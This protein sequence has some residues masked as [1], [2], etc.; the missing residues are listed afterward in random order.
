MTS[1]SPRL[2]PL[3]CAL[4]LAPMAASTPA[5]AQGEAPGAA[6]TD[7]ELKAIAAQYDFGR[8]EEVLGRARA[9]IDRGGLSREELVQLHQFAGLA[10]FN[11][12]DEAGAERHFTAL[13]KLDPDFGL[14]PFSVAPPAIL[15]FNG[16]KERLDPQ[17]ELIRQ[18][19]RVEADRLRREAEERAQRQREEEERRRR[20]EALSRQVT[21]R[22]VEHRS[23][24]VNFLPFG[25]PQFGQ[26]R[27]VMGGVLAA[28]QSAAAITSVAA[29]FMLES[30]VESRPYHLDTN[31]GR[32]TIWVSG[33]PASRQVERDRWVLIK[34]AS[35]GAFYTLYG[36][37]VVDGI[38]HHQSQVETV[39]TQ[40]VPALPPRPDQPRRA[41][42]D[43]SPDRSPDPSPERPEEDGGLQMPPLT[44]APRPSSTYF[45]FPTPGGVGAG[46]SLRF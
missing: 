43:L 9:R 5:L 42:P 10:A 20:V 14:D 22:T 31:E 23:F 29:Y 26:D 41:P 27:K 34:H 19:R 25:A 38:Y 30:M 32:K 35:A 39:R 13:L 37:G 33:I 4:A 12:G 36:F 6:L 18:Q 46:L 8:Y 28:A 7:P 24:L 45:L 21:V 1:A 44:G 17:L 2:L 15:L 40:T 11:L 3:L 16:V